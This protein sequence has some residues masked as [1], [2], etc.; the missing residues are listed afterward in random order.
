MHRNAQ[1]SA[2]YL[3]LQYRR[4]RSIMAYGQRIPKAIMQQKLL[5]QKLME[6]REHVSGAVLT[7]D[8]PNYE[9]ARLAWNR[10][11]DQHPA[12]I[13]IP[14][15]TQDI[16]AGVQ[17]ARE[18][19]LGVGIQSTGHGLHAPS[20]DNLLIITSRLKQITVD[21]EKQIIRAEAGVIWKE[22]LEVVT[23]HGLAP[24]LGS[25]PHVGIVGYTLGGGLGWLGRH[26]G[27]AVDRVRAI[28]IV[29]PDGELRRASD[30]EN[31]DLFWG[32]RG[33][34][35]NFGVVTALEFSVYPVTEL[36]GGFLV[37]PAV[38]A[39]DAF[40]FF[41]EWTQRLPDEVTASIGIMRFPNLPMVPEALRGQVQIVLRAAYSGANARLGAIWIQP[42]LDWRQPLTNTF[43]AMPFSDVGTISNDP[44][45]PSYGTGSHAILD[46]M[47]DEAI[48]II[49]KQTLNPDAPLF[50]SEIR[51]AGGAISRV[52]PDANAVGNRD[53]VY[54]LQMAGLAQTPE[55]Y[56]VVHNYF[57]IYKAKLQPYLRD[58]VY[59]NFLTE[60]EARSSA[61]HG[62][63]PESYE[64]LLALKAKY[65][66]DNMFRYGFQ[67]IPLENEPA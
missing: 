25:S 48:N 22:V 6:F 57:K 8:D 15:T 62:Y 12:V 27:L 9:Q 60:K 65:D 38:L 66:P 50:F 29:T 58:S 21:V 36:Y 55:V 54:Y 14:N 17:F 11:T 3:Y 34:V 13:L 37:Y 26:Y 35:G 56:E 47:S 53:A 67:L 30:D 59:L 19:G 64:R 61:K 39:T 28:E 45:E 4:R 41:R 46:T 10:T 43:R 42:W 52:A 16:V 44:E 7:P 33:G 20:N 24:L 18:A 40:R 63:L 23:P 1:H 31:P 49:V 5:Q 51:Y 2:A 32:L